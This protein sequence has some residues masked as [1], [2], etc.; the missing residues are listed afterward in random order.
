[1]W[2]D[3]VQGKTHGNGGAKGVAAPLKDRH[4]NSGCNPVCAGD[5]LNVPV[6]SGLVVELICLSSLYRRKR[7]YRFRRRYRQIL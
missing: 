1:M 7:R 3:H 6:I 2:L 5:T 4:A